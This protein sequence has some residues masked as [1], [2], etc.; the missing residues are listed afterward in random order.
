VNFSFI[1]SLFINSKI[2]NFYILCYKH[3]IK[4]WCDVQQ[5]QKVFLVFFQTS[6][7]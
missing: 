5:L 7:L 4:S 1:V 3:L 2:T 6:L